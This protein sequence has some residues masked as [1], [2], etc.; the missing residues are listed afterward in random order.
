[1][2]TRCLGQIAVHDT[3]YAGFRF[4][5][6]GQEVLAETDSILAPMQMLLYIYRI[7]W[8]RSVRNVQILQQ[9]THLASNKFIY[10]KASSNCFISSFSQPSGGGAL[11][12][13]CHLDS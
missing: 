4:R 7:A 6:E 5:G 8:S 12:V 9:Y 10:W 13:A 11:G 1:M 3:E 2:L